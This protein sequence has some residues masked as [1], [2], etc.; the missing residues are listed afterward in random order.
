MPEDLFLSQQSAR[1]AVQ[2]AGP[3][4]RQVQEVADAEAI[5]AVTPAEVLT[6]TPARP[7]EALARGV[8]SDTPEIIGS[9]ELKP[10]F[11]VGL[12]SLTPEGILID[13]QINAR[14]LRIDNVRD[15]FS[16]LQEDPESPVG[17][18]VENL[19]G[20]LEEELAKA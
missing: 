14:K 2:S 1:G 10:I 13:S 4:A 17:I 15:L 19:I 8:M 9:F 11:N 18:M 7:A 20:I 3:Q 6:L 12:E 5:V 16:R